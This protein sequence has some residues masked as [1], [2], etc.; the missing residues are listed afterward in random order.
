MSFIRPLKWRW[1]YWSLGLSAVAVVMYLS[2][3]PVPPDTGLE[4][5]NADKALHLLAYFLM[6]A[7]FS[8]LVRGEG[9]LG[10]TA[11]VL[12]LMGFGLEW[13]QGLGNAR[14][15]ELADA[16]ANASGVLLAWYACRGRM[17]LSLARMENKLLAVRRSDT[18]S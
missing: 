4:F 17:G 11:V 2:L 10:V 18:D 16:I 12:T 15:R 7:W 13:L 9:A 8:Q 1:Y 3:I 6:G 14:Q 5:P